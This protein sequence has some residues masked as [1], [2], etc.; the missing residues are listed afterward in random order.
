MDY[1]LLDA[2]HIWLAL[3]V[4]VLSVARTARLLIHD[5]FP[6][7]MAARVRVRAWVKNEDSS[8]L[9]L[10][11]CP[12]CQAPYLSAVMLAWMYFSELHWTWWV[13]NGWWAL[14][15]VAAIIYAYDQPPDE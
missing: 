1:D 4:A 10:I 12:F 14:S 5:D 3:A 8:W 6:P 15:Y 9:G 11:D 13:L 2:P 7:V